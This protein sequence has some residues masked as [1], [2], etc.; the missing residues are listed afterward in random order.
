MIHF[1]YVHV[2]Q[3]HK[4]EQYSND[5]L[6]TLLGKSESIAHCSMKLSRKFNS[7][8]VVKEV[9]ELTV[10]YNGAL[11]NCTGVESN[12]KKSTD[13]AFQKLKVQFSESKFAEDSQKSA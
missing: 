3:N 6:K 11:F 7:R 12:F 10:N 8:N 9:V 1:T 13:T 2:T 5:L 4:L